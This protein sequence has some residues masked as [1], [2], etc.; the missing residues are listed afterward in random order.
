MRR[1]KINATKKNIKDVKNKGVD[2][3]RHDF[4]YTARDTFNQMGKNNKNN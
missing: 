1:R 2:F 4:A 3:Y